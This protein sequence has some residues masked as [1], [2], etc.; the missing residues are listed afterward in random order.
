MSM[1][2]TS[3]IKVTYSNK[4]QPRQSNVDSLYNKFKKNS[5]KNNKICNRKLLAQTT[6]ESF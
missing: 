6:N 1:T 4:L 3:D 5:L 2:E